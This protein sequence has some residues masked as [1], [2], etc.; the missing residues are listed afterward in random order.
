MCHGT[1][2]VWFTAA[3]KA[4]LWERWK[5][6]Q[7]AAAISRALERKNKTG[8][9]RIV[10]LHGGIMP[11]PR[12]RALGAPRLEER[13]EVS[14]G[15]AVGR[16]IRQIAQGLGRAPSTV[17]REIRRNGGSQAYRANRADRR[18]WERALRPALSFGAAQG[19]TMARGAEA[20]A[21]MVAAADL[22]LAE[23]GVPKHQDMQISHEAIYRSLFIQ[24]RGVLKK[25]LTAQLRTAR[26][27]RRPKSH[28]AKS[29]QGHSPRYGLHPRAARRD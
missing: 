5:N 13:E 2:P 17:S 24:T 6:G 3:Q 19:A 7:S 26:R 9:E 18:A 20:R 1:S 15:I 14:R 22:R 4:E 10:V 21:A 8:V 11:V 28:N 23:A 27:M 12:R 25:E 29:G 16:S